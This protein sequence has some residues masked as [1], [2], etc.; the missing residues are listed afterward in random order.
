[1]L[2]GSLSP[3]LTTIGPHNRNHQWSI[4]WKASSPTQ[5][6][7]PRSHSC[8]QLGAWAAGGAQP[9]R[10]GGPCFLSSQVQALGTESSLG[11]SVARRLFGA[12][13]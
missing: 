2:L 13:R 1:M 3:L 7:P 10:P 5:L 4:H 11:H 6:P 8:S 9:A 12:V